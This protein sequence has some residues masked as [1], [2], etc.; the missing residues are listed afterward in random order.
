MFRDSSQGALH[1]NPSI[2][3][4]AERAMRST[5]P[6]DPPHHRHGQH[7]REPARAARRSTHSTELLDSTELHE[8]I[9][10]LH[11]WGKQ[12]A[13]AAV[14]EAAGRGSGAGA[15]A[16]MAGP[17]RCT[18]ATGVAAKQGKWLGGGLSGKAVS[19][20]P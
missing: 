13:A 10:H 20:V 6:R 5:G 18:D 3:H 17:A 2:S 4:H 16:G 12:S 14:S 11:S 7:A 19:I 8:D 15:E 1:G 9:S